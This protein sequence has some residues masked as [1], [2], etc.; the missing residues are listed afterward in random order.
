MTRKLMSHDPVTLSD[1]DI[2]S[3]MKPSGAS[4]SNGL[5]AVALTAALVGATGSTAASAAVHVQVTTPRISA[6]NPGAT[7]PRVNVPITKIPGGTFPLGR[8]YV[9]VINIKTK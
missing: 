4:R 7:V 8:V 1:A 6:G 5:R 2:V 9:P 3:N